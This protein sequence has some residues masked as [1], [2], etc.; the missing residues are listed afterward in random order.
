MRESRF[1]EERIIRVLR[2]QEA[3]NATEE[4]CRQHG[5]STMRFDK[6]KAEY[7]R[8]GGVRGASAE[9]ARGR[10]PAAEAAP[11]RRHARQGG[12]RGPARKNS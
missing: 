8:A 4:V 10:E 1:S 2:E 3:G 12:A 5:I 7:G 6:W 9:G 11:G